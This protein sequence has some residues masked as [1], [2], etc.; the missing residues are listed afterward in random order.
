[1]SLKDSEVKRYMDTHNVLDE[2]VSR[3]ILDLEDLLVYDVDYGTRAP[4]EPIYVYCTPNNNVIYSQS[5]GKPMCPHCGS[6]VSHVQQYKVRSIDD[7]PKDRRRT[8]L[9]VLF[10]TRK[11]VDCNQTYSPSLLCAPPKARCTDRHNSAIVEEAYS[12]KT[13][14]QIAYDL[15]VSDTYVKSQ[16]MQEGVRRKQTVLYHAVPHLGID[17]TKVH[18]KDKI[19]RM[20]VVLF[21]T[22]GAPENSR[23]IALEQTKLDAESIISLLD[24][25][26]K[27]EVIETV[28]MDMS[29][30]FRTAVQTALPN[31]RIIVDRFHLVKSLNDK[32]K[33]VATK[34]YESEKAKLQKVAKIEVDTSVY[35][36]YEDTLPQQ[37]EDAERQKIAQNLEKD[38]QQSEEVIKA[39]KKLACLIQNYNNR[40]FGCN[41]GDLSKDAMVKFQRLFDAFPMFEKLY[42]IKE[43]MR[44]KFFNASTR[45]EAERIAKAAE[46]DI[47]KGREFSPLR[48]YFKTLNRSDWTPYIYDYFTE[49]VG[50]RYTNAALEGINSFIKDVNRA[51]RGL[52][53]EVLHDKILF[54]ETSVKRRAKRFSHDEV[55]KTFEMALYTG[56]KPRGAKIY[57]DRFQAA[58]RAT[59]AEA[60]SKLHVV[61]FASLNSEL[62]YDDP[63]YSQF[64]SAFIDA[65]VRYHVFE[66]IETEDVEVYEPFQM[67]LISKHKELL[68]G[69]TIDDATFL[70]DHPYVVPFDTA[71]DLMQKIIWG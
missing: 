51:S 2:N 36:D 14:S 21:D 7:T 1:M 50:L 42:K 44:E 46:K 66:P 39:R 23:L 68:L 6:T 9:E 11:C 65:L 67:Q 31:A 49:P 41:R 33:M 28:T 15:H 63:R 38:D 45:E 17:E 69:L 27:P 62:L 37:I 40:R 19:K 18:T 29:A 34:L 30:S 70:K 13:F 43:I 20:C 22:K 5:G 16:F 53:W 26:D 61:R 24:K 12:K 58:C 32:T 59:G 4:D 25:L 35:D 57:A 64:Y 52:T 55:Q 56:V 60:D 3:I 71:D 48:T 8:V 10:A 54:G 47:P